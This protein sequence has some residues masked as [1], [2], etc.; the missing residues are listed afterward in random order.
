MNGLARRIGRA[1][2]LAA[3]VV[4]LAVP[5]A[6]AA[7]APTYSAILSADASCNLTLK[8][9][10]K[11]T[12]VDQVFGIWYYDDAFAFSTVAPGTGPNAGTLKGK[13]ATFSFG[14]LTQTAETHSWRVLVQPYF[15]GAAQPDVNTNVLTVQCGIG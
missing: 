3:L 15:R 14:P 1:A 11:N 10:W 7:P 2:G 4:A 6:S 12:Q 5:A 9:T 13:T 8:V